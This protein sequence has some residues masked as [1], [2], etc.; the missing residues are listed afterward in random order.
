MTFVG[1]MKAS[2]MRLKQSISTGPSG[3]ML[4]I[5]LPLKIYNRDTV[6]IIT[7]CCRYVSLV[8]MRVRFC[9][10][11]SNFFLHF[12]SSGPCCCQFKK[13]KKKDAFTLG[14]CAGGQ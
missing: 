10:E 12:T 11:T 13:Q 6:F 1:T 4:F 5:K 2:H 7:V 8:A 9:T 3:L 14:A